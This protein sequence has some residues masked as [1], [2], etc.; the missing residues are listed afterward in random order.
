MCSLGFGDRVGALSVEELGNG[1]LYDSQR[2]P[3]DSWQL[4]TDL[5]VPL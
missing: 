3:P 4:D 1:N 5:D 2:R